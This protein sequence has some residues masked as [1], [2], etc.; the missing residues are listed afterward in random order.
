MTLL[1]IQ[2]QSRL[3]EVYTDSRA[4]I[5]VINRDCMYDYPGFV[6]RKM[7]TDLMK[8]CVMMSE[9]D[10]PSVS[11]WRPCSFHCHAIHGEW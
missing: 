2:W 9:F 4:L 6:H 10:H 5:L 1:A 8:E 3:L 11:G 7:V